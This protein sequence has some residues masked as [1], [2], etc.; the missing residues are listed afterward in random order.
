MYIKTERLYTVFYDT[1]MNT[2]T[3][4]AKCIMAII[5]TS[6]L[7]FAS[8]PVIVW[9]QTQY[10]ALDQIAVLDVGQGDA[11]VIRTKK[12]ETILVDGG[13][14][15]SVVYELGKV[16]PPHEKVIDI[17]VLTHPDADHV[18]GLV[19][20]L[21]RYEVKQV[22]ATGVLHTLP[23]YT[24]FWNEVKKQN[25][26]VLEPCHF[27]AITITNITID[28]LWPIDCLWQQEVEYELNDTSVVLRVVFDG[29]KTVLL[30]GDATIAVEQELVHRY[31]TALQS[32]ILKVGHHGSDTSTSKEFVET[33]SPEIALISA[34]KDNTYGHPHIKVLGMLSLYK[35]TTV[36]TA[37]LGTF[38]LL[39]KESIWQLNY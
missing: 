9:Y 17:L 24:A 11:I 29:N 21:R 23:A 26:A 36:S 27:K 3:F 18:T 25:L 38:R 1:Y 12:G 5:A 20:V 33:V 32:D 31:G 22:L 39:L 4:F 35:A 8:L 34:G 37:E 15:N 7:V 16:L 13:P 28:I 10:L 30:A 2:R 19:E 6:L 14:D